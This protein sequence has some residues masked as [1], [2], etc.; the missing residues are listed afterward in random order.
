MQYYRFDRTYKVW[1][2]S[3]Y[4][5]RVKFSR[6]LENREEDQYYV[7]TNI[8]SESAYKPT[9][10]STGVLPSWLR[11]SAG[12]YPKRTTKF[13]GIQSTTHTTSLCVQHFSQALFGRRIERRNLHF[14][15][16]HTL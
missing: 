2:K 13:L 6:A 7:G 4:E 5:A 15:L 14:L 11:F 10:L 16:S 1:A 8:D 9:R 12:F 3:K